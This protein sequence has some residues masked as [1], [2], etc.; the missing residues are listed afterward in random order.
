[1]RGRNLAVRIAAI[2]LVDNCENPLI[3][4]NCDHTIY[5]IEWWFFEACVVERRTAPECASI[6]KC[7]SYTKT[8][9]TP[10]RC[11]K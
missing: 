5:F 3:S 9:V 7:W 11:D 1:M 2:R 8:G 6:I 10:H 4:E